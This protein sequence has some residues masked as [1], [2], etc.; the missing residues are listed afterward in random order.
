MTPGKKTGLTRAERGR[1]SILSPDRHLAA[2]DLENTLVASNVVDSFSWIATRHLDARDRVRFVARTLREA[3]GLLALDR[4]D[5]GDFLRHF[6][7]RYDGAPVGRL[8]SEVWDMWAEH[9]MNKAFPAALRRVRRHRELGH[10]TILI[11]GALDVLVAPI[12]PLFD[13]VVAAQLDQRDGRYTGELTEAPCTGEARAL[14]IREYCD[15][16]GLALEQCVAY[17]DS[18]SDLPMLEV[19]GHPVAVNAEAKLAAIARKRGWHTEDWQ[20]DTGAPRSL[21]LSR[22]ATFVVAGRRKAGV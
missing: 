18:A 7:R 10:R 15:V 17:A 3:P 14:A 12:K 13:A 11:T 21:P 8:E 1:R 4:K 16:E 19:V 2:F 9:M 22:R 6:Y 5:R 20:R